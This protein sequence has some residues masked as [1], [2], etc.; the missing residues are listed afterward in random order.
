MLGPDPLDRR[1][2]S[3]LITGFTQLETLAFSLKGKGKQLDYSSDHKSVL[4][5]CEIFSHYV[6]MLLNSYQNSKVSTADLRVIFLGRGNYADLETQQEIVANFFDWYLGEEAPLKSPS[7]ATLHHLKK[8]SMTSRRQSPHTPLVASL[9][10][11]IPP[12]PAVVAYA[13]HTS[14][15][16]ANP[17]ENEFKT[18]SGDLKLLIDQHKKEEKALLEGIKR[19]KALAKDIRRK[20]NDISVA[21]LSLQNIQKQVNL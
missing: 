8:I 1:L 2:I 21:S 19:V 9:P 12:T 14:G 6:M 17:R 20:K 11:A 3:E 5:E 18:F 15:Y 16:R 4:E 13:H 7:E 10:I